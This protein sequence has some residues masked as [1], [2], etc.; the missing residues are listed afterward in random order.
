MRLHRSLSPHS[1]SIVAK[2][3]HRAKILPL[4]VKTI[5][6]CINY[7]ALDLRTFQGL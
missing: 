7:V 2:F 3:D 6:H 1:G 4:L 5:S